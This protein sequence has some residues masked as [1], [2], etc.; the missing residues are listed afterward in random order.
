[1]GQQREYIESGGF[2]SYLYIQQGDTIVAANGVEGKVVDKIEG[3]SYDGLPI[4]S[5]TSEV[6]LSLI[7]I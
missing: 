1:M 5:N 4:F 6:Y 7:H 3:S 2:S